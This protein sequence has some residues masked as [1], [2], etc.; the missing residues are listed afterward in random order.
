VAHDKDRVEAVLRARSEELERT[1]AAM[2]RSG[3][4]MRE[5]ELAHLHNHPADEGSELHEQE[6]DETTEIFLEEEERR[7]AEAR[8]ALEDGTYGTCKSCGK[9]IPPERLRAVPEAVRCIDCQRHF[10]GRHR[11][12]VSGRPR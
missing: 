12:Q 3:Q 1:R 9:A 10:E 7:I 4:G 5:G 8:R 2:R 11:Q 6:V